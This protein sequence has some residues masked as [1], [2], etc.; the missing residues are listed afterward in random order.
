MCKDY[1]DVGGIKQLYHTC[2]PVHKIIDSLKVLE[3][4]HIQA[5]N[6]QYNHKYI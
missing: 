4:L 3:Y 1:T 5:D 2:I 6:P